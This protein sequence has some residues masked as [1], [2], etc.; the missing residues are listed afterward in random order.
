MTLDGIFRGIAHKNHRFII[1]ITSMLGLQTRSQSNRNP[2]QQ[3][4]VNRKTA[5]QNAPPGVTTDPAAD[6]PRIVAEDNTEREDIRLLGST[7]DAVPLILGRKCQQAA[8]RTRAES[9]SPLGP[10]HPPCTP[11]AA[12]AGCK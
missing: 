3:V 5:P 2:I 10:I 12:A 8:F 4:L 7:L 1:I 9:D 11:S 6:P